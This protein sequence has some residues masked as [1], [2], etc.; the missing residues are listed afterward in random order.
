MVTYKDY[1]VEYFKGDPIM[2]P[3]MSNGKDPNRI[4]RV[5]LNTKRKKYKYK[6]NIVDK[7]SSGQLKKTRLVGLA[8][9]N[10]LRKYKIDFQPGATKTLGN[11]R[12]EVVM[13]S[14]K[15]GQAGIFRKRK[16]RKRI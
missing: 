16:P 5:H 8:L 10:L 13:I 11:S 9:Q 3:R 4:G 2:N 1:L 6:D 14:N 15:F 12:V 7:I